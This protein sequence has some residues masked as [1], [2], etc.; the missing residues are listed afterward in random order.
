MITS[1]VYWRRGFGQFGLHVGDRIETI[2]GLHAQS[3]SAAEQHRTDIAERRWPVDLQVWRGPAMVHVNCS[4]RR[5][6]W[7][8]ESRW[9]KTIWRPPTMRGGLTQ[10]GFLVD[11]AATAAMACSI[12]TD[13]SHDVIVLTACRR[14]WMEWRYWRRCARHVQDAGAILLP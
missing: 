14:G 9:L 3:L 2:D 11:H 12:A 6:C 1:L 13:G 5:E 10:E 4:F 8:I 7:P